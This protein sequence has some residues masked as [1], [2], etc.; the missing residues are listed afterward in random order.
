MAT[1]RVQRR[2]KKTQRR[3]SR[4]RGGN[5][6][7]LISNPPAAPPAYPV[8][9]PGPG[10]FGYQDPNQVSLTG[11]FTEYQIGLPG[12][13][14]RGYTKPGAPLSTMQ[15]VGVTGYPQSAALAAG[16]LIPGAAAALS[17]TQSAPSTFDPSKAPP[18]Y[19]AALGIQRPQTPLDN[20]MLDTAYMS[21]KY[22]GT[23]AE[24]KLAKNAYNTLRDPA[25]RYQYDAAV[26]QYYTQNPPSL[27]QI[28]QMSNPMPPAPGQKSPFP[29]GFN[30][31]QTALTQLSWLPGLKS[32]FNAPIAVRR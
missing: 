5:A 17:G 4:G 1:R 21:K 14:L 7:A 24:K 25:K 19:Y 12:F 2:N 26:N 32:T 10:Q 29:P 27:F 13:G 16:L 31:M 9:K 18:N 6:S 20:T 22:I 15:H 23:N 8:F 3:K 30:P 28:A 11:N